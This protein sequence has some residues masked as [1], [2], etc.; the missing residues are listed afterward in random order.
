[1]K[2]KKI[3]ISK[4]Y[5]KKIP[6]RPDGLGWSKDD[7]GIVSLEIENKGWANKIAQK[8]LKKPKITYVHLDTMGSFIWPLMDG[9]MDII[10][11]GEL[12]EEHFGEEAHPLYERLARYFQ[13]LDSYHFVKWIGEENKKGKKKKK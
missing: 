2:K 1:M 12:V 9:E 10:R 8:L 5:L 3:V 11:I 4:N 13:I 6:A 7:E